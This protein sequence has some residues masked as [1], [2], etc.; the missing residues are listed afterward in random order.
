MIWL[1]LTLLTIF[2]GIAFLIPPIIN[3]LP[4]FLSVLRHK[5]TWFFIC[6]LFYLMSTAGV[7]FDILRNPPMYHQNHQT[8]PLI[9]SCLF[10]VTHSLSHSLFTICSHRPSHVFLS[11]I[12]FAICYGGLYHWIFKH[13]VRHFID[14][15]DDVRARIQ[16]RKHQEHG[17]NHRV[18]IVFLL[19]HINQ[20]IVQDEK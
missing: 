11:T 12:R 8:G 17:I 13:F 5:P 10:C 2:G 3:R 19:F 20:R 9:H 16:I 14:N 18:C 6:I 15:H 7:V 4:L 1:Y